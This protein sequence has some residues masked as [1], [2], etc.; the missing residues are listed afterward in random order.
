MPQIFPPAANGYARMALWALGGLGV[1]AAVL[2]VLLPRSDAFTRED[3]IVAQPVPFSH[4]HHVGGLGI[5]CRYCHTGVE[6]S[7]FAGLP[8][9]E[10][11][12]TCHSQLWTRAEMLAPVRQSLATGQ[13]IRWQRVHDLADYV[14]FSHAAHVN[15]GVGCVTCHG[16]VDEMPLMRQAAPLTMS[17]CLDCH[18]DPAPNLRPPDRIFAM[19]EER[20]DAAD[21]A[22]L[23]KRYDI[24][25][26]T[27]TDCYVCHR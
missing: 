19:E 27:M 24:H 12:M 21:Q 22:A 9:T 17:W 20:G 1:A 25:P 4:Q 8:P 11:C 15:N 16:P 13:P 3:R 14:Y 23:M 18:R 6:K 2:S 26:E 5:D 7:D 10:T